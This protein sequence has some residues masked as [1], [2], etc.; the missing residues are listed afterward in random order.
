MSRFASVLV[1]A[2]ALSVAALPTFADSNGW[3]VGES[4]TILHTSDG[5]GTWSPQTSGTS[6]LLFA[7]SFVDANDGWAVGSSGTIL[8]TSNGGGT[9]S[10][11]T[12]GTSESFHGVSFVDANNGWAMGSNGKIV[13]TSNGGSTWSP[14]VSKAGPADLYSVNMVDTSNGWATGIL[15]VILHTSDGGGTWHSL[16][17]GS[18]LADVSFVDANNGWV[19]GISGIIM[20]TTNGGTTWSPQSSG[21][22]DTLTGV[23]FVDANNGWAVGG[24]FPAPQSN[25]ILHTS[26]GGTTWSPQSSGISN[27]LVFVSFVDANDGWAV[28]DLGAIVHTSNG[29]STWSA[30]TSGTL[31][32]FIGVSFVNTPS[33]SVAKT[34]LGTFTQGQTAEWD[35]TVSNATGFPATSGTTTL[36]DTLPAGYTV[37]NFS[38]TD[39]SWSC[40]GAGTQTATC[41]NALA[42]NGGSSF[43]PVKIIVNIPADSPTRVINTANAFGGGD[44]A[45][46]TLGTAAT[47]SDTVSV[48]Q[49]PASIRAT[50]GTPQRTAINTAFPTN[51]TAIVLDA[52]GVNVPGVIVTFQAPASGPSG[53]F[54]SP[55]SG[56]L[57]VVTADILGVAIAPTFTANT[58]PGLYVVTATVGSLAPASFALTNVAP[59]TFTKTFGAD[60]INQGDTMSVSF[61]LSNPNSISLTGLTFTDPLPIG[62]SIQNPNGLTSTCIGGTVTAVPGTGTISLTAGNLGPRASCVISMDVTG[63]AEGDQTNASVTLTSNE[64]PSAA[65]APASVFVNASLLWFFY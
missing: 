6:V 14:Q 16:I 53:T 28:G 63:I 12:S 35:I 10:P 2:A 34:H 44:A 49:V 20:H 23:K 19:V 47:G 26:N 22:G 46:T 8:H 25:V 61:A 38:T 59:P 48:I 18:D 62:L 31:L 24:I 55:C 1:I 51:L 65:S 60:S 37:N 50:D 64:A 27:R 43:L 17:T 40:S 11:Q 36:S 4:G 58:T 42:V 5:G 32:N 57:C 54:A 21:T 13:H 56:I 45:H 7:V 15:G 3:A 41:T 29:G 52:K 9:W 39:A 33:L 30:Q